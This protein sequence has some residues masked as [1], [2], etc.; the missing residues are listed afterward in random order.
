MQET[1]VRE[2]LG[3]VKT[4]ERRQPDL[5]YTELQ[6]YVDSREKTT[7]DSTKK[8]EF[9]PLIKVVRIRTK[10]DALSTG[11]VIVDLPGMHDSNPVRARVAEDYMQH[12]TGESQL[13][14]SILRS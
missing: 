11:A 5:F 12:C 9:W 14:V 10:A 8:M 4:V 13:H 1:G 6:Q 7:G 2:V 3:T